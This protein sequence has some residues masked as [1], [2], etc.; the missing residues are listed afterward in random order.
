MLKDAIWLS[1]LEVTQCACES[2]RVREALPLLLLQDLQIAQGVA[3]VE[4][5]LAL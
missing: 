1:A 5:V 4:A 3:G 2:R